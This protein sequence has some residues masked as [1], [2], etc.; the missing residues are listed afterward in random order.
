M[1]LNMADMYYV[2][3]DSAITGGLE[4]LDNLASHFQGELVALF[5]AHP[6]EMTNFQV[7]DDWSLF[8]ESGDDRILVQ[9]GGPVGLLAA[10]Q[11]AIAGDPSPSFNPFAGAIFMYIEL[12]KKHY[13]IP[14]GDDDLLLLDRLFEFNNVIE[15]P[16]F[17]TV[18]ACSAVAFSYAEYYQSKTGKPLSLEENV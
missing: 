1:G 4:G 11:A 5:K 2:T 9:Y 8:M 6:Q 17:L 3:E 15:E 10:V 18:W 12:M 16:S 7:L 13:G 14:T